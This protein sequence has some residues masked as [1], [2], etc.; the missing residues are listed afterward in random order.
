MVTKY[1]LY[2]GDGSS[3]DRGL[4]MTAFPVFDMPG[5]EV[6]HEKIPGREGT[7]TVHTG[8]YPD[9][10]ITL[11]FE[12][13]CDKAE[14]YEKTLSSLIK[15]LK[16][17]DRISF[18]DSSERIYRVKKVEIL[19]IVR[20]EDVVGDFTCIFTLW[21]GIYLVD[22]FQETTF[23]SRTVVNHYD[24]C[25]PVYKIVGE[26]VCELM[27][28]DYVMEANVGQ[29]ITIDTELMI[30][31]RTDGTMMNTSVSGDYEEMWLRAGEN[32]VAITSGFTL[33]VIPRWRIM[34]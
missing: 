25:K 21:P 6:S 23:T 31:Y 11:K 1:A 4:F 20:D 3:L 15:W 33:T 28:N 10:K 9:W 34:Q 27:V 13:I 5:E 17:S 7:L 8:T 12:F 14:N 30:A 22:G 24:Y 29:N 32:D 26:G 19:N 18:T 16:K 2:N